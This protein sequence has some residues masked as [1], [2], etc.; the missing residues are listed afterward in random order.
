MEMPQ[1][2]QGVNSKA[3][4]FTQESEEAGARIRSMDTTLSQLFQKERSAQP[5]S[6]WEFVQRCVAEQAVAAAMDFTPKGMFLAPVGGCVLQG[7]GG[8]GLD[9]Q[10]V[11][12]L[13][14][15]VQ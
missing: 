2:T 8:Q 3:L 15:T 14:A 1:K 9:A 7:R 10:G 13:A 12:H 6:G 4:L 11:C 5:G